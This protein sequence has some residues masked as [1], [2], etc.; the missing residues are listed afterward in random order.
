MPLAER[1]LNLVLD[2]DEL[3]MLARKEDDEPIEI[4]L[5]RG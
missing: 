4:G 1:G 3:E 5:E 2:Y